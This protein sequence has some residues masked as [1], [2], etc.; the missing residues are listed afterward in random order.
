MKMMVLS[1]PVASLGNMTSRSDSLPIEK[2]TATISAQS[3]SFQSLSN[4]FLPFYGG[5]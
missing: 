4:S 5:G 3:I 1:V 2:N